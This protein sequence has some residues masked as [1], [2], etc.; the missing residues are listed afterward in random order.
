M[1]YY[2]FFFQAEDGIRHYKVTGVQ[3]CAL[4]ISR[5]VAGAWRALHRVRPDRASAEPAHPRRRVRRAPSV[6][7]DWPVAAPGPRLGGR[8]LLRGS[9][10]VKDWPRGGPAAVERAAR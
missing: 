10:T 7:R 6:W 5:C 3:T 4:P 9:V 2:Y 8:I 1:S